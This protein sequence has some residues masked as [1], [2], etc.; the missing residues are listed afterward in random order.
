[1][2]A[3]HILCRDAGE[4]E[5]ICGTSSE[6]SV[7]GAEPFKYSTKDRES[8]LQRQPVLQGL[9][10]RAKGAEADREGQ[11]EAVS[12][13]KE[14]D[15]FVVMEDTVVGGGVGSPALS[16]PSCLRQMRD[17]GFVR[18]ENSEAQMAQTLRKIL[19]LEE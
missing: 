13:L 1:M 4:P 3:R 7:V 10:D 19:F 12:V 18:K 9:S 6:R 16:I 2:A 17:G 15:R 8:F 5:E 11:G 14:E